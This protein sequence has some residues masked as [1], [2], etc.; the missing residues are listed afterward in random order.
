MNGVAA[1]CLH[2]VNGD[3]FTSSSFISA[4]IFKWILKVV[5]K[6]I[7]VSVC[8]VAVASDQFLFMSVITWK[9]IKLRTYMHDLQSKILPRSLLS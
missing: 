6:Q 2:G 5:T 9:V 3:N 7:L 4:P 8:L 1:T